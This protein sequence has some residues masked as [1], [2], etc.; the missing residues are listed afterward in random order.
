MCRC[1]CCDGWPGAAE[2]EAEASSPPPELSAS[3]RRELAE[4]SIAAPHHTQSFVAL[5]SSWDT[6][7]EEGEGGWVMVGDPEGTLRSL[8]GNGLV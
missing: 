3:S 4:P 1:R 7:W 5:A 2:A 6:L 8:K